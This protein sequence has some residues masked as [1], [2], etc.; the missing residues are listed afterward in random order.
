M[1]IIIS[2]FAS[3][4]FEWRHLLV[5]YITELWLKP[6]NFMLLRGY[7]PKLNTL[8]YCQTKYCCSNCLLLRK[9]FTL[10]KSK[11]AFPFQVIAPVLSTIVYFLVHRRNSSTYIEEELA[12]HA[13]SRRVEKERRKNSCIR[14]NT[15]NVIYP[16]FTTS[17]LVSLKEDRICEMQQLTKYNYNVSFATTKYTTRP[18]T[19]DT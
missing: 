17:H 13:L 18:V 6:T 8:L 19:N 1:F 14:P 10:L 4:K 16:F 3:L 5:M 15:M 11:N 9:F 12:I 7:F 2:W